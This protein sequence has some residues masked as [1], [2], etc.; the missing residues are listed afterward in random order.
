MGLGWKQVKLTLEFGRTMIRKVRENPRGQ[1]SASEESTGATKGPG[2]HLAS[3]LVYNDNTWTIHSICTQ[4][5]MP[6]MEGLRSNAPLSGGGHIS[7]TWLPKRRQWPWSTF[8]LSWCTMRARQCS[9][10]EIERLLWTS[11]SPQVHVE[12]LSPSVEVFGDEALGT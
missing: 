1:L 3:R 5:T 8:A 9:Q 11:P 12:P 6:W 7:L 4:E 10:K 2:S